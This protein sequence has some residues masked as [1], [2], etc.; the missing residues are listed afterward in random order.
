MAPKPFKHWSNV[1]RHGAIWAH[2]HH[3][4]VEVAPTPLAN[5]DF[6]GLIDLTLPEAK[7]EF[8]SIE[9]GNPSVD[10]VGFELGR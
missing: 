5:S 6:S 10:T 9:P 3:F 4:R 8:K 7:V 1:G 2:K